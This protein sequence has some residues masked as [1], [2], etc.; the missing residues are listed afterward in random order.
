M[1]HTVWKWLLC[2]TGN[3]ACPQRKDGY[4]SWL[5]CRTRNGYDSWLFYRTRNNACPQR[6]DSC[7]GAWLLCP[8]NNTA[9]PEDNG[10]WLLCPTNNTARPEENGAWLFRP[11]RNTV[12]TQ[13]RDMQMGMIIALSSKERCVTP[14]KRRLWDTTSVLQGT[15]HV[16]EEMTVMRPHSEHR[17]PALSSKLC[18][19]WW[20]RWSST[21]YIRAAV[22]RRGQRPPKS[23]GTNMAQTKLQALVYDILPSTTAVFSYAIGS[24]KLSAN[25]HFCLFVVVVGGGGA[26]TL[27]SLLQ[28]IQIKQCH[29]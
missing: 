8:T 24:R 6:K 25:E 19:N 13:I 12:C 9:R 5:F 21:L 16:L 2:S 17:F 28:T 10:A 7:Y 22:H 23:S 27:V 18:Q 4:G 20:R 15:V 1:C 14:K 3:N 29:L 26:Q 11:T